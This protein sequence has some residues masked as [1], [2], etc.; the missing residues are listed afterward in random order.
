M[1]PVTTSVVIASIVGYLAKSLNE[2]KSIK[3]FLGDFSEATIKW[4]RP[5]FL[6]EDGKPKEV[7]KDLQEAPEEKLNLQAAEIELQKAVK[8]EPE[9][10]QHLREIYRQINQKAEQGDQKAIEIIK[11]KNVNVGNI[12]AG[13]N[14]HIGDN[15]GKK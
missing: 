15:K 6:K 3:K 9:L 5:L 8:K 13:G 4:I 10:E 11:S 1:E 14:V 12:S 7:I 2:D